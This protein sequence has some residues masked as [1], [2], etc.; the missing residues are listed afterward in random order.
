MRKGYQILDTG[1]NRENARFSST[2][3]IRN[4]TPGQKTQS[5][6]KNIRCKYCY[7]LG[8]EDTECRQKQSKRP[9]SMLEWVSIRQFVP[10]AKR[11][12]I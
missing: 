6:N 11:R 2:R 1:F 10:N 7:R 8:H 4:H 9:P 12:D 3:Q 5:N